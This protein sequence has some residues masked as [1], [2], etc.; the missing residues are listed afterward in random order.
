MHV[1]EIFVSLSG[2]ADGFNR[3]GHLATFVRLQ[4]CNLHCHWC[5]TKYASNVDD[6]EE[7]SIEKVIAQCMTRH[8]IITGGEPLLQQEE[9]NALMIQLTGLFHLVTLETNGS[10]K[11]TIDPTRSRYEWLRFVVDYKLDSSGEN[12]AMIPTVFERLRSLDVIK[13]VIADQQ[14]YRQA[15][16]VLHRYPRWRAHVVFSPIPK[17]DWPAELANI[18]INDTLED[19]QLSLQLHKQLK[20]K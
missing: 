11:I 6:A 15:Q 12:S 2:E 20:I 14:D 8:I 10:C 9:V 1:N 3:Q 4:G 7:M 17:G 5:D 16:D 13:F 19:I 18:M